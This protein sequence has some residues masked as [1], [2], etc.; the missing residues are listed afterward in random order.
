M[1]TLK[2]GDISGRC[3][4]FIAHSKENRLVQGLSAAHDFAGVTAQNAG[5]TLFVRAERQT[6]RRRP[7]TKAILFTIGIYVEPLRTLSYEN[8]ERLCSVM[9]NLVKGEGDRRRAP[10][11]ASSLIRYSERKMP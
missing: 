5:D 10:Y 8:V 4:R 7:E 2:S 9:R 6:L 11:Y 3:N 1:A